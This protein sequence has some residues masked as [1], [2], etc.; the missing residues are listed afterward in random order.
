MAKRHKNKKFDPLKAQ[1]HAARKA[2]FAL[3][4]DPAQWRP[5]AVCDLDASTNRAR[6]NKLECRGALQRS[7]L[8]MH[9]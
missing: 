9:E 7:A 5:R 2:H 4:G 3:C 1:K 6:K 8:G